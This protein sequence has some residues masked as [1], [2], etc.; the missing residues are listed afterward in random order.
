MM[1]ARSSIPS[2][3]LAPQV[4]PELAPRTLE[5][6]AD[7][8]A[9]DVLRGRG[10]Q[11][12]Q[13]A[14]A[15]GGLDLSQSS[16]RPLDPGQ[17]EFYEA[18]FGHDFR[19]L[20]IHADARAAEQ[21]RDAG[22]RAMTAGNDIAFAAGEYDPQ[23]E[24]GQELLAHEIAHT[25]QQSQGRPAVQHKPAEGKKEGIGQKPPEELFTTASGKGDEEEHF[26]FAQDSADLAA[27]VAKKLETLLAQR[28]GTLIVDIHGYA[29]TEGDA[30]YNTNLAAHRAAAVERVLL[31]MLPKGSQAE[32]Y[33]HGATG[34]WG[35]A[36]NNRRAGVHIWENPPLGQMGY[37]F[38]PIVPSLHLNVPPLEL[39]PPDVDELGLPKKKV[40]LNFHPEI[41]LSDPKQPA[42]NPFQLP[43][44]MRP[45]G[46]IDWSAMREPF[47]SRGIRLNDND[48]NS[49]EQNWNN[50]YLWVLG[51]GLDPS[52]A[53][54]AANK[55]TSIAYDIQLGK[56]FPN[57]WDKVD[58]E[59]KKLGIT[60]SPI[61]PIVTPETLRFLSKKI[62]HRDLDLRFSL[63]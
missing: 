35:D 26:L 27:D 19:D 51:I 56:E 24:S 44:L 21:A 40:D 57:F 42:Y 9:S 18:Q 45:P 17:R 60:K 16:G 32:L 4:N 34:V 29:S 33:S 59:D 2:P 54:T 14:A 36:A 38:K 50:A 41:K 25:V 15:G 47:T 48:I 7:R 46:V 12:S 10:A 43:P 39:H 52:T 63:P 28:T 22:A 55:L 13:R 20:R 6:E 30:A 11:V 31:P 58:Q 53:A 3:T 37:R 8:A 49:V 23:S 62:F 61:I 1:P 5:R